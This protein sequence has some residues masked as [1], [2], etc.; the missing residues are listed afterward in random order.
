MAKYTVLIVDDE[1]SVLRSFKALLLDD[2]DIEIVTLQNPSNAIAQIINI[3]PR[4]VVLDMLMG[5]PSGEEVL[6]MIRA[7]PRTAN[8]PVLYLT[9]ELA[10]K[11]EQGWRPD[12]FLLV[13]PVTP[14]EFRS[15]VIGII[16]GTLRR[17]GGA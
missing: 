13:K 2:P 7:D 8:I 16:Q 17:S 15:K 9:G 5:P 1:T 14:E 6:N 11:N 3:R 10:K 4:A 12:A